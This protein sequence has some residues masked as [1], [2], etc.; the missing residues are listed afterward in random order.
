[1][2]VVYSCKVVAAYWHINVSVLGCF[3][4]LTNSTE[5]KTNKGHMIVIS[6]ACLNVMT[7]VMH[8]I[9]W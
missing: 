2:S 7:V 4:N 3:I 9:D 5:P 1:M 6:I 8:L